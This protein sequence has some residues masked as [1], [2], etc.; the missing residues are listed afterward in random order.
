M[1]ASTL[2]P[3]ASLRHRNF[4]IFFAGQTTSLIGTWM[5]SV[6]QGWLVLQLTNSAFQVGL[7]SALSA[8]PV[9]LFS[10]PAGVYVDRANKHRIILWCQVLMLLQAVALTV[11]TATH[12][13]TPAHVMILA[14][15]SGALSA[16]EIPARQ[17][18]FVELVGKDDLTNAI[19]LNSSAYNVARILG[20][21]VAGVLIA[22]VSMEVCFAL[23][24]LS[25]LAVILGLMSMRMPVWTRPPLEGDAMTRFRE[26]ISFARTDRRIWA[27]I[28]MTAVFAIFG[29][30]YF[31]LLPIFARDV[32]HVGSEGLGIMSAAVGVG[33]VLGA[34]GLAVFSPRL[35]RG[36]VILWAGPAFGVSVALFAAARWYPLALLLLAFSGFVM[37][38]NNAATNT[39]LQSIVPDVLRGRVMAFWTFVFV[40]FAPIGSLQVGWLGEW[41][42]AQWAV[43]SGGVV[44]AIAAAWIWRKWAQEVA[45]LR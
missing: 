31:V 1:P 13:V 16:I 44:C 5:Q 20:P 18:F 9:L 34:L 27:M 41:I 7:V 42:G 40:G 15:F 21:A 17:S 10:L 29:F 19:A 12:T 8:L 23:N 25:Y 26:G 36:Q 4:R 24:A 30:P 35:R 28:V 38:L 3:F 33:A 45:Q 37:V 14:A 2:S 11:L 32:L 39:L 43:A 6:A 22:R